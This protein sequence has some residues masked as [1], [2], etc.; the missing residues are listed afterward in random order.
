MSA[1]K[2]ALSFNSK[3]DELPSYWNSTFDRGLQ[4]VAGVQKMLQA[5]LDN[6]MLES[7][8]STVLKALSGSLATWALVLAAKWG[9]AR[10]VEELT[11]QVDVPSFE[12]PGSWL[13]TWL[14][15]HQHDLGH[16]SRCHLKLRKD[17]PPHVSSLSSSSS[18]A[19]AT[20][21][22]HHEDDAERNDKPGSFAKTVAEFVFLP[23]AGTASTFVFQGRR[24]WMEQRADASGGGRPATAW[25]G[26]AGGGGAD[27]AQVFR[28]TTAGRSKATICALLAA[29][30]GCYEESL[31][32]TTVIWSACPELRFG[33]QAGW[34]KLGARPSRPLHT[35]LLEEGAAEALLEDVKGFLGASA[36]YCDRGIPYRRGYLLYGPPGC[37]KTS[38]LMALAGELHLTICIVNLSSKGLSDD[39]LLRLLAEAP[40]HA[41]ILL[42][43]V[44]AAFGAAATLEGGSG[45]SGSKGG[46]ASS[47][48]GAD[49]ADGRSLRGAGH[50]GSSGVTFSGLLN[51]LDGV[52]A[53]EG[54]VLF[55]TT[56]H[57]DR[58]DPALVRPGRVD[59]RC[60][61]GLA[62]R[63]CAKKFFLRFYSSK[64]A[65]P[66]APPVSAVAFADASADDGAEGSCS[67]EAATNI[68]AAAAQRAAEEAAAV[69]LAALAGAFSAQLRGGAH[70][71]ATLQGHFMKFRSSPQAAAA[72]AGR[73]DAAAAH[74]CGD[75]TAAAT[76]LLPLPPAAQAA[77]AGRRSAC[78][79]DAASSQGQHRF[80]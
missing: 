42:E 11:V 79:S 47:S 12:L 2:P 20:A 6:Q 72:H 71:M 3:I 35:V 39:G 33:S 48:G 25:A 18:G 61:F 60:H 50:G 27:A 75:G 36:W 8:L 17:V 67:A 49:G 28:L 32:T 16:L 26:L 1:S 19:I 14:A 70:A 63:E 22:A 78:D 69:E 10:L 7:G 73:L 38:F 62:S 65:A 34:Q 56:N 44:D 64:E 52:A 68:D 46:D 76:E 74:N 77:G 9:W 43:D 29:A 40:K 54:K 51:A 66:S 57:L 55:M 58:L 37:G 5:R 31:K 45:S 13:K 4:N 41:I 59:V 80:A 23:R 15:Q 53:Q 24:V 30:K 21:A